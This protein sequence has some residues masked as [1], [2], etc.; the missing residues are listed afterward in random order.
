MSFNHED[1]DDAKKEA[2]RATLRSD[3]YLI[4]GPPGTGKTKVI[5]EIISQLINNDPSVRVLLTSQ[6]NAAVDNALEAPSK[7]ASNIS[8]LRIG[9]KEKIGERLADYQLDKIL[10]LWIKSTKF[11]SDN[12]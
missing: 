8:F 3:I 10:S 7:I 11:K 12:Y 9:R 2:V 5:S 6:S 4:Q 1:L